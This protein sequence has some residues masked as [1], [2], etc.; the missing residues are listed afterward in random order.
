MVGII[1]RNG[2]AADFNGANLGRF[3]RGFVIKDEQVTARGARD[4]NLRDEQ[5][6]SI[7][8]LDLNG[9]VSNRKGNK[10]GS[11]NNDGK[12]T[13][14]DGKIVAQATPLQYYRKILV[15]KPAVSDAAEQG[16]QAALDE[17]PH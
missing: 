3:D 10:L 13:S 4:Y 17:K 8:R 2:E 15:K 1:S 6:L 12:F 11:I 9:E 14:S 5:H 7:G 16:V